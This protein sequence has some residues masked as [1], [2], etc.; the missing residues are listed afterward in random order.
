MPVGDANGGNGGDGDKGAAGEV[1]QQ[2]TNLTAKMA[3]MEVET[4]TL[5]DAK[6]DLEQRLDEADKELL[7]D[8]YLDFKEK[9]GKAAPVSG[10]G[11]P[12]EIDLDR[13]S[14]R[15]IAGFIEG[16]YKG[17]IDA[18]VKDIKKE[19]DLTRQQIGMISAQFDVALTALRHD[20]RDGKADWT[21][22]QKAIFEVAKANPKWGAE[23]CYQQ[24]LLQSKATADEKVEAD[25]KKA[26]EDE[27]A[28][29]ERAGVPGST[30]QGKELTEE[31]AATLGYKKA[32]GNKE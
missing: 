24:F 11:E 18:A 16:K 23:Q 14:N 28:A 22:N 19:Q 5:K 13:A 30:V 21:T 8:V 6:V 27:K 7:S 4:K 2:L 15:E 26:E 29:T 10:G 32:F 25:R 17:D 20:G 1:Q 3:A 12:A 31:E 9:K